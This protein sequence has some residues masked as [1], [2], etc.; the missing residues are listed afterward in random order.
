IVNQILKLAK[1][2]KGLIASTIASCFATNLTCS[3]QYISI[4]V[5]SRMYANAYTEKGLHSKNLS[6]ALEDGGTLTSVFVPW[7]T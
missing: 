4:V 2:A 5:P 7:N 6:R 3:E 1:S